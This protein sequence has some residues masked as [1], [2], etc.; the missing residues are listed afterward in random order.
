MAPRTAE[1]A[2]KTNSAHAQKKANCAR[3]RL[4]IRSQ[5]GQILSRAARLSGRDVPL[6][7]GPQLLLFHRYRPRGRGRRGA[8][9]S[10]SAGR[11]RAQAS[12][13]LRSDRSR[14]ASPAPSCANRKASRRTARSPGSRCR[15]PAA[16]RRRSRLR[17]T[18]RC[19]SPRAAATASAGWRPTAPASRNSTCRTPAAR[20][21]S[22]PSGRMAISGSRSTSA[23]AWA[24]S[25]R[26][27]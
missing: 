5:C 18:A 24:A 7:Y 12:P 22:S 9:L 8:G 11:S 23:T 3:M 21:G 17:R 4:D 16:G 26:P 25:R 1:P 15:T 20:R 6:D 10:G 14:R 27:A 13:A 19:G 2:D